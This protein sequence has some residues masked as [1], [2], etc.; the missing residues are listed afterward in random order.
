MRRAAKVDSTQKAIVDVLRKHGAKVR[1]LHRVG[2]G[3]PDLL[4]KLPHTIDYEEDE[5][6]IVPRDFYLVECKTPKGKLRPAQKLFMLE[7]WPVIV[8][9]SADDAI[10][11]LQS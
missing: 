3:I 5:H 1:H 10:K 4:V 2:D 7:G 11:W 6:F 8:L 9:H